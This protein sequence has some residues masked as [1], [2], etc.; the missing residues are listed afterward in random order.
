MK[1]RK[2]IET[3]ILVIGSGIAGVCAAI[4][5]ASEGRRVLLTSSANT[6]SGSTFYPG[7]WGFGLVGPDGE[8]DMEE[9]LETI[10]T[11]G[12]AMINERVA[13]AFVEGLD[14]W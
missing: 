13:R 2:S 10:R 6:F 12:R 8:E 9:L 5:A 3:D 7:T 11:V 1:L 14:S 4:Y